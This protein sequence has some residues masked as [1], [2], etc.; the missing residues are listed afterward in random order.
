[1]AAFPRKPGFRPPFAA[2]GG[3]SPPHSSQ[4]AASG[5]LAAPQFGQATVGTASAAG[6]SSFMPHSSQKMPSSGASAPQELH[7]T[8]M[9]NLPLQPDR[10]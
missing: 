4:K 8:A 9:V 6:L 3:I 7:V 1:M 10:C 5:G 2:P